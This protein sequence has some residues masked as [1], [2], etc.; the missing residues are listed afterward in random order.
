MAARAKP[1][2][3]LTP[4]ELVRKYEKTLEHAKRLYDRA[5]VLLAE[6]VAPHL[7]E[8]KHCGAP[9]LQEGTLK[10]DGHISLPDGKVARLTD[11]FATHEIQ[12]GHGGVRPYG[13]KVL[14]A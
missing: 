13:V 10:K 8:C 14:N 6:I 7:E 4:A 9:K 12:W 3:K 1:E 5:D 11:N 2:K